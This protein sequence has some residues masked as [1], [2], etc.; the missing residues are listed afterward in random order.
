MSAAFALPTPPGRELTKLSP[1]YRDPQ[2]FVI[3][4]TKILQANG[5]VTIGGVLSDDGLIVFLRSSNSGRMLLEQF[6]VRFSPRELPKISGIPAHAGRFCDV[7]AGETSEGLTAVIESHRCHSADSQG[8][9]SAI[10]VRTN[11]HYLVFC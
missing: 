5:A 2:L 7:S 3:H 1:R 6:C 10:K 11:V 4:Y 8:N 9:A